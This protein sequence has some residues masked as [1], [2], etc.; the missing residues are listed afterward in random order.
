[1]N[2]TARRLALDILHC[3]LLGAARSDIAHPCAKAAGWYQA[4]SDGRRYPPD[5]WMGHLAGARILFVGSNPAAGEQGA[6]P[7]PDEAITSGARDDVLL[8]YYDGAFDAGQVPGVVDGTVYVDETG[9]RQSSRYSVWAKRIAGELLGNEELLRPGVDYAMTEVVHCASK[10]QFGTWDA[11]Q[12]CAE[13]YLSRLLEVSCAGVVVVAGA[14]AQWAFTEMLGV[15]LGEGMWGPGLL[16]G[17]ERVVLILPHP[18]SPRLWGVEPYLGQDPATA[19]TAIR[20]LVGRG[21]G[22][23]APEGSGLG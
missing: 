21:A 11:A 14:V 20:Q 4:S 2:E 12:T 16:A 7:G 3:E 22:E 19:R 9:N 18:R 15:A 1:M 6:L 17:R 13:R 5:P 10:D 8:A 23:A